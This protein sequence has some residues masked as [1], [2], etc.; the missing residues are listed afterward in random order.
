VNLCDQLAEINWFVAVTSDPEFCLET[1]L[2]Y[3]SAL[4]R[5]LKQGKT[6]SHNC[7]CIKLASEQF[8]KNEGLTLINILILV[9][10]LNA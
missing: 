1:N 7:D 2:L 5:Y 6:R 10:L 4:H 9:K 8:D 3:N